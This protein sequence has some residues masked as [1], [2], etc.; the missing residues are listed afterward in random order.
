MSETAPE[1]QVEAEPETIE[2][3]SVVINVFVRPNPEHPYVDKASDLSPRDLANMGLSTA[4]E[5]V[6][7]PVESVVGTV[8]PVVTEDVAPEAQPVDETGAV[9]PT[10]APAATEN[11]DTPAEVPVVDAPAETPAA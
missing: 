4:A 7:V 9:I 2:T 11:A 8:P 5:A 10:P 1:V 3:P 6:A